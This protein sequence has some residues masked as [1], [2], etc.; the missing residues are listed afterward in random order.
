MADAENA[1]ITVLEHYLPARLTDAEL[2]AI[3]ERAVADHDGA[4][5]R[6]MGKIMGQL[7][8][9]LAG[10]ADMSDVS[11]RLKSRLQ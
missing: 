1:E 8:T 9:E 4:T 5:M 3:I 7:K 6:D 11:V 10:Q 2:D